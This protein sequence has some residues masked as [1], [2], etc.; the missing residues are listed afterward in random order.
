MQDE[1]VNIARGV[2]KPNSRGHKFSSCDKFTIQ[3]VF[4]VSYVGMVGSA[5]WILGQIAGADFLITIHGH[6]G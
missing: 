4:R 1:K 6:T 3:D 2:F 5:G